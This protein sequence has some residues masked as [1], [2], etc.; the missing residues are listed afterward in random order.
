VTSLERNGALLDLARRAGWR[1]KITGHNTGYSATFY[2][3]PGSDEP[4][5]IE[6]DTYSGIHAEL[7]RAI[8]S[9]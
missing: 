8:H 1:F 4:R 5:T 6:S 9:R 3:D 2:F 7:V